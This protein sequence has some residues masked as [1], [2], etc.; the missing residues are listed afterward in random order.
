M[1]PSS[2]KRE[3]RV[4]KIHQEDRVTHHKPALLQY[5]VNRPLVQYVYHRVSLVRTQS[6]NVHLAEL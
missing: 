2:G 5:S 6:K 4:R 3:K 1:Y